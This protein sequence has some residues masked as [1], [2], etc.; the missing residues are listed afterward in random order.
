MKS[1]SIVLITI[2]LFSCEKDN[3]SIKKPSTTKISTHSK[4]KAN[5]IGRFSDL[6]TIYITTND[7]LKEVIE[8]LADNT[9][10][11]I[12]AGVYSLETTV[13]LAEKSNVVISGEGFN[14]TIINIIASNEFRRSIT[15]GKNVKS[16]LVQDISF[17]GIGF[18]S[19]IYHAAIG[20]SLGGATI[21]VED[22]TI[23]SIRVEDLPVGIS[24]GGGSL[25]SYDKVLVKENIIKNTIGNGTGFGYGIHNESATNV[26]IENN[27][28][29]QATR[30]SI[31]QA[32]NE[33]ELL[34]PGSYSVIIRDILFS[35]HKR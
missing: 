6:D 28:I 22:I 30:H 2:L 19:N 34:N 9:C 31:Y 33:E 13:H 29:I 18:N 20:S 24:I 21:G 25:G 15:I 11:F 12:K 3:I 32:R 27:Q 4:E 10:A 14:S 23:Q 16:L 8:S 35:Y 7:D 26:L 1:Y 5:I 17:K